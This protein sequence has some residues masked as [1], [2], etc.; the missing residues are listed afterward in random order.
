MILVTP[1]IMKIVKAIL[2]DAKT[3]GLLAGGSRPSL[4]KLESFFYRK[5]FEFSQDFLH[6]KHKES[7]VEFIRKQHLAFAFSYMGMLDDMKAKALGHIPE[8]REILPEYVQYVEF[9]EGVCESADIEAAI[10]VTTNTYEHL[11]ALITALW[12][13]SSF[14]NQEDISE[15]VL[16]MS[17]VLGSKAHMV[18][19]SLVQMELLNA[20]PET[21]TA[22]KQKYLPRFSSEQYSIIEL[23][24]PGCVIPSSWMGSVESSLRDSFKKAATS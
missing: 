9:V 18:E 11:K 21:L 2:K 10:R 1:T 3:Y 22:L 15:E 17:K 8:L 19:T 6:G 4:D 24:T 23:V 13:L 5:A 16:G 12:S 14:C 20:T 7:E